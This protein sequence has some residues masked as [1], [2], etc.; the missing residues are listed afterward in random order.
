MSVQT[1]PE[2]KPDTDL[3]PSG[4]P[5]EFVDG[6]IA[7]C[8]V[9]FRSRRQL[10]R[11]RS[12]DLAPNDV[13]EWGR[14]FLPEHF[15]LPPSRMHRW[16][17]K[18]L[19]EMRTQRGIKLNVLGPRGAAK[20]TIATLA[21][22]LR[23]ALEKLEPYIWIVSDTRQQA[24][25]HLENV[26]FELLSNEH[27]GQRYPSAV[28]RGRVW[29]SGAIVLRNE[30][31]IEAYG[32]GQKIR[33]R[34][35]GADRPTLI[36]CDDLQNDQHVESAVQR[37]KARTW[38]HGALM[39]AGTK[40]TNIINLATALHREALAMELHVAPGWT[41]AL[42][43]AIESWPDDLELWHAWESVYADRENPQAKDH[44]LA[45]YELH[46][47]AMDR[48]AVLLWPEEEDLYTLMCMRVDSGRTSFEREKQNSPIN[49]D[50]CEWP[51]DYFGPWIWF[52]DWPDAMALRVIALDPS[53]GQDASLGDYSAYVLL[54]VHSNGQYYIEADLAR[55]ATPQMVAD[56]VDHCRRFRPNALAIEANQYQQ[57]L[58]DDFDAEFLRQQVLGIAPWTIDNRVN[59]QVRIRRLGPLLS[60]RRL[61]FKSDSAATRLLVNQ[62]KDFP[63]G[64]YDDGP[65]ALEMAV[66]LA[67][68]IL[69]ARSI[70]DGLGRTLA[71]SNE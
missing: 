58:R 62:L 70:D 10:D 57:L 25:G 1:K 13:L 19:E 56:G 2:S 49:P 3:T 68:E 32:T 47:E 15:R 30:V 51:E 6:L 7:G 42:F 5:R 38:F 59:K 24:C 22:V 66:R 69:G 44:A 37:A 20:S 29:R 16:M 18:R 48:G 65:D 41:S 64:E 31:M 26:K 45:Q 23:S 46:R 50:L 14:T 8:F 40:R 71:M 60:A 55:R 67:S 36:V 21:L 35:K 39:K 11:I 53:K 54:G 43:R 4:V 34:R 9:G 28:G 17:A 27:L 61:R 52:N 63:I 12:G 33:G